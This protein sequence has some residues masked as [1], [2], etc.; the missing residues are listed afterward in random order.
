MRTA[1]LIGVV[2]VALLFAWGLPSAAAAADEHPK[3]DMHGK[4][5]GHGKAAEPPI[6][7]FKPAVELTLW[8]MVVFALLVAV[9]GRFAW[10]PIMEGLRKREQSIAHDRHE[11]DLARQEAGTLRQELSAKMAEADAKIREMFDKAR[12]DAD[13]TRAEMQAA[14]KAELQAERDRLYREVGVERDHA[15]KEI[16]DQGA[17]LAT[18]ISA[19]AIHKQLSYEDHRALVDEALKEFRA[20][21]AV[22][23]GDLES[24]NA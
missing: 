24:R 3:T 5:A 7:I 17:K 9:L 20:A 18:L 13:K 15:L 22:R 14:T 4:E 21:A 1:A 16:W 23:K 8:T 11:A 6:E 12:Q 10:G 19:K 2:F